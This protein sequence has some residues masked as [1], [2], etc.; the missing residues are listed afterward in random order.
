[1][2]IIVTGILG[3]DG[4]N[5]VEYLLENTSAE[6]YGMT[7]RSSN[8]N[9][10]ICNSFISNPRFNLIYGDL[11]DSISIDNAVREIQP[12]YFINLAAQ[13]F[14]GSS[15]DFP[16]QT[17]ECQHQIFHHLRPRKNSC[18]A[19]CLWVCASGC[20]WCIQTARRV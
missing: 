1:M 2:K 13:T 19:W 11:S 8:P 17:W 20:H 12:D 15:W 7:R 16:A 4:A 6:I 3:Q 10:I 9:F 18:R 14:V 5:M